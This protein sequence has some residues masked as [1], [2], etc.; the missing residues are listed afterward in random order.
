LFTEN[1]QTLQGVDAFN[2]LMVK[3]SCGF[4]TLRLFTK[5]VTV[6]VL[7]TENKLLIDL[8]NMV[9]HCDIQYWKMAR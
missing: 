1:T 6:V 9:I 3:E 8:V 4:T 7:F 2:D 5:I